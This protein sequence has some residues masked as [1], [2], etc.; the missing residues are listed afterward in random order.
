MLENPSEDA[1]E[2]QRVIDLVLEVAT[3]TAVDHSSGSLGVV[4]QDLRNRVRQS[5]DNASV[6]HFGSPHRS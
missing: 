6:G 4:R 5:E 1:R 2:H 3:T